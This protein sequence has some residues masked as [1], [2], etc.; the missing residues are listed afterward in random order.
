MTARFVDP[1][2][3]AHEA[4]WPQ[5]AREYPLEQCVPVRRFAVR[6]GRRIAP[7]W[8][9]SA[10]IGR[11]VHYGFGAMRTQVMMLDH[12]PFVVALSCR[13]VE[14]AW[15][16]RRG[17]EVR[18][19]PHLMARLDDGSGLLVDCCG[20]SG[21]G[22]RLARRARHVA[23]AADAVGWHYRLAGPPPPVVEANVRWLA[24]YRHPRYGAGWHQRVAEV[25]AQPRPLA[26][27][28]A[29]L[30]DPIAAWPPVYHALWHGEL[31]GALDYPL[32]ERSVAVSA[33]GAEGRLER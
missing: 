31:E 26:E 28:V 6:R 11:F 15:H 4:S 8:Y 2:G 14:L 3:G 1:S 23:A 9:W 29:L 18:H 24:G 32:R 20:S 22:R 7:G 33:A 13:P 27:G 19:A 16:G 12:D 10:T 17:Q 30:G 25:F 5:A 21:A